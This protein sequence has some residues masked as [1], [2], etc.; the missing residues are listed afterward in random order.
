MCKY[1]DMYIHIYTYTCRR[2]N[3]CMYTHIHLHTKIH[4]YI[5]T[6]IYTFKNMYIYS[7]IHTQAI[8]AATHAATHK[9]TCSADMPRTTADSLRKSASSQTPTRASAF[10]IFAISRALNSEGCFACTILDI[11]IGRVYMG[12]LRLVRFFKS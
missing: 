7:Y 10:T 4:K 2:K 8:H 11:C 3:I 12:W 1:V 5:Q 6:Y 9:G